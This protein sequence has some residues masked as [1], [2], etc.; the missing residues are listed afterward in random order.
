MRKYGKEGL[1]RVESFNGEKDLGRREEYEDDAVDQDGHIPC[2]QL[3]N[4]NRSLDTSRAS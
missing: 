4:P 3:G 1:C 2:V